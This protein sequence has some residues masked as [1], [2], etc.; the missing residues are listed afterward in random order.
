MHLLTY[1]SCVFHGRS[2]RL[3]IKGPKIL[4]NAW[5]D[6]S[7]VSCQKYDAYPTILKVPK[8]RPSSFFWFLPWGH[9]FLPWAG[10]GIFGICWKS[11]PGPPGKLQSLAQWGCTDPTGDAA[12]AGISQGDH[13]R[14]AHPHRGGPGQTEKSGHWR[15]IRWSQVVRTGLAGAGLF[16][17]P[18]QG[19]SR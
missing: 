10:L 17:S 3:K 15:D 2:S 18:L 4:K 9:R 7:Y 16:Q 13:A 19:C 1:G 5:Y 11:C 12:L 8:E 6:R 14:S